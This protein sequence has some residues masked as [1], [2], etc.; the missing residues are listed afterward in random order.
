[1]DLGSVVDY[2]RGIAVCVAQEVAASEDHSALRCTSLCE[3]VLE[4]PREVV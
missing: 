1:M 3:N 2:W 4:E